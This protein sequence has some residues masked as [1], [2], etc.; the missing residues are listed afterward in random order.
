MSFPARRALA[1]IA[2][3]MATAATA[4][5]APLASAD[6]AATGTVHFV[7]RSDPSFD[8]FTNSPTA[9]FT[10]WMNAKFWRTEVFTPYFDGK[11]S[12]Y[13]NGWVYKDLYAI[14][15]GSDVATQHPDWILHD[16]SGNPLYIPWGC[17]NGTCPQYA[18]D[19]S[20]PDYRAWWIGQARTALSHGYKGLWVDDVN[21]E[22]RVGNGSGTQTAPVDTRIGGTMSYD[23]WRRYVVEFTEAIRTGLPNAEILH[24]AIWYAVWRVREADPYVQREVASADYVNIEGAAND[25]GL[26]SGDGEWSFNTWL[27]HIDWLH[28]MGKGAILDGFDNTPQGREYNLGAYYLVNSGNDGIGLQ[29]MTPDNWW[30]AYDFD[31]GAAHGARTSW[32]GVWRRDF[33][34]GLVLVNGPGAATVT[35][36][37]PGT[38]LDSSGNR[39]TS[40][41]LGSKQAAVLRT[42]GTTVAAPAPAPA[43]TDTQTVLQPPAPAPAPA[44]APTPVATTST[45]TPAPAPA[46]VTS[47]TVVVTGTVTGTTTGTVVIKVQRKKGGKLRTVTAK[48]ASVSKKGRFTATISRLHAGRK[49]RVVAHYR[50]SATARPSRSRTRTFIARRPHVK[51]HRA[52]TAKS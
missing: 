13:G 20:N 10:Q 26:T 12:W 28:S 51:R 43:P 45:T 16:A 44:P 24:N 33:D 15:K 2:A 1:V 3:V 47:P 8:P 40:V 6:S 48:S 38:Y 42:D 9:G 21:L 36:Q 7:K 30:G 50:G 31:L 23:N 4:V 32:N 34:R 5:A 25:G 41:T 37:L 19:V 46:P 27:R 35:L 11:T 49:Y 17:S 22:F 39:V 29:A 14:Y 52:V 18:A